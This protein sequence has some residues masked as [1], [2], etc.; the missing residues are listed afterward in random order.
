MPDAEVA[1]SEEEAAAADVCFCRGSLVGRLQVRG[2]TGFQ[3]RAQVGQ[4]VQRETRAV[5]PEIHDEK[6]T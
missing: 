6:V 3:F 2:W 5:E 1:S 4:A